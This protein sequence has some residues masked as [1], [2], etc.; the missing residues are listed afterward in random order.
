MTYQ[1]STMASATYGTSGELLTLQFGATGAPT[2][3]FTYNNLLQLTHE[4]V[5][6]GIDMQYVYTAGANSGRI[7]QSI[8][9]ILGETVNYSYDALNRLT[10]AGATGGQWGRIHLMASG[11]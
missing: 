10:A 2:E 11:T 7:A 8:D 3:T 6:G 1:P 4:V 5:P 9:G